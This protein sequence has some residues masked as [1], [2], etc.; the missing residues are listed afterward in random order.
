M[1][2]YICIFI[3]SYVYSQETFLAPSA[4]KQI[5][6]YDTVFKTM[7]SRMDQVKFVED[8]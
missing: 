5:R 7:C 4:D 1:G 8:S 3:Q 2:T 6:N